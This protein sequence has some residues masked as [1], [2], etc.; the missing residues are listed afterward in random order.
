VELERSGLRGRGV[1]FR[2]RDKRGFSSLGQDDLLC[3]LGMLSGFQ[4]SMRASHDNLGMNF[5]LEA[6]DKELYEEN[7][8]HALCSEIQMLKRRNII[9]HYSILFQLGQIS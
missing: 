1:G 8:C 2:A 6:T 7:I 5:I 3:L 9:F 4:P